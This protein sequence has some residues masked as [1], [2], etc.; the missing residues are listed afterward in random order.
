[1]NSLPS[2]PGVYWSRT[3]PSQPVEHDERVGSGP[4]TRYLTAT[5][6]SRSQNAVAVK[7]LP[8]RL[9]VA[10][11]ETA[12][13]Q[14]ITPERSAPE[15]VAMPGATSGAG[16]PMA[17]TSAAA[18]NQIPE[19][20]YDASYQDP[21]AVQR[22]LNACQ[23][24]LA[25]SHRFPKEVSFGETYKLVETFREILTKLH[26]SLAPES[27]KSTAGSQQ[28]RRSRHRVRSAAHYAASQSASGS[29]SEGNILMVSHFWLS[30]LGAVSLRLTQIR[31]HDVHGFHLTQEELAKIP[32]NQLIQRSWA[33]YTRVGMS[34][35]DRMPS[36]L[37]Q[38]SSPFSYGEDAFAIIHSALHEGAEAS[39]NF[40]SS[41]FSALYEYFV[42]ETLPGQPGSESAIIRLFE[43]L[44]YWRRQNDKLI[45]PKVKTA[46]GE[47]PP[48]NI[49]KGME[50]IITKDHP[51]QQAIARAQ[52]DSGPM[53]IIEES[54]TRQKKCLKQTIKALVSKQATDDQAKTKQRPSPGKTQWQKNKDKQATV[55]HAENLVAATSTATTSEAGS[56]QKSSAKSLRASAD[57]SKSPVTFARQCN[58][59]INADNLDLLKK[60]LKDNPKL[61]H[62]LR[63][64]P[65][66]KINSFLAAHGIENFMPELKVQGKRK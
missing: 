38:A 65:K 49:I 31:T 30:C 32:F 12:T 14:P 51:F 52:L 55:V 54:A 35:E 45:V 56:G 48:M 2:N 23:Q 3:L 17:K 53:N 47:I 4:A 21:D 1:M 10:V 8:E 59:L 42:V 43:Q 28:S 36:F 7:R 15:P 25:L 19:P 37:K 62:G 16:L 61:V 27:S 46:K 66:N 58:Q 41:L 13:P 64:S 5:V 34:Y 20:Q 18:K 39:C 40:L 22:L 6:E 33:L 29:R 57:N 50:G 9:A 26:G 44:G 11:T 60:L 24:W 63:N